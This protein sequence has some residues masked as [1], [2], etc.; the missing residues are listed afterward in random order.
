MKETVI[1]F[2]EGNFL[3]ASFDYF[4]DV[5]NKNS[6]YD[7]KVVVV[8]PLREGMVDILN[9]QNGKYNLFIRGI[10]EGKIYDEKIEINSISRGINCY[11]NFEEYL[12]LADNPDFRFIVSNTTEAGIAFSEKD[13]FEDQPADSFPGKLTQLLY[14]RYKK[15]LPGFIFLPCELIDNNADF[16]QKYILD[17]ADL[18]NLGENFKEWILSENQFSNTLVDGITTGYPRDDIKEFQARI[19]WHDRLIDVAEYFNL[20]VIEGNYEKEL[21]LQKAGLSVIWTNDVKPYKKRKVRILNGC[22]TAMVT[23]ALLY[24]LETVKDCLDDELVSS[25]LRHI[26]EKEIL[27]TLGN[28]EEDIEFAKN[29]IERFNNPFIKH[30]LESIALNSIA[31]YETRVLPTILEYYDKFERIPQGLIM[32]FAS[33]IFYYKNCKASDSPE[34]IHFVQESSVQEIIENKDFWKRDIS[35]LEEDIYKYYRFIEENGMENTY[36]KVLEN[37]EP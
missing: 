36:I 29:V 26:I 22:H 18:W 21:P 12:Q 23:G 24:N 10:N 14:R 3:R 32:S 30:Y 4:I 37:V 2:G 7:G 9:N 11:T 27:P 15:K 16:L 17:Y 33:L 8:Q 6:L 20:W 28:S 34:T 35:F 1:Q 19:S 13:K 5:L 31:K 25:Y